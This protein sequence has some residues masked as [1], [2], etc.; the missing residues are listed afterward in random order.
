MKTRSK[1]DTNKRESETKTGLELAHAFANNVRSL[2]C[3]SQLWKLQ[4]RFAVEICLEVGLSHNDPDSFRT[5]FCY[6]G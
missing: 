1:E 2:R 6:V 5:A 3:L 4:P